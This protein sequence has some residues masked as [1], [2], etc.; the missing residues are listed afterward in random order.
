[1]S[2]L[3]SSEGGSRCGARRE[4]T[5]RRP[6]PRT[7]APGAHHVAPSGRRVARPPLTRRGFLAVCGLGGRGRRCR[8]RGAA[9]WRRASR[10]RAARSFSTRA[11][12]RSAS[13]VTHPSWWGTSSCTR[14]WSG[15]AASARTGPAPTTTSSPHVAD[16]VAAAGVARGEP[17]DRPRRDGALGLSSYPAFSSPQE[18]GAAEAAAGFDVALRASN[19]ALRRGPWRA[20]TPMLSVLA[21]RAP[22]RGGRGRRRQ[23]GRRRGGAARGARR[24]PDRHPELRLHDERHPAAQRV[25]G[26]DALGRA[27]RRRRGG[28]ARGRRR[29]DRG[30]PALGDGVHGGPRRR[31][32]L[33]GSGARGRRRGPH[34]GRPSPRPAAVRGRSSSPRTAAR[35][36][37]SGP[38]ATSSPAS[39]AWTRWW[40]AWRAPPSPS[41]GDRAA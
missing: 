40:A 35:C 10:G 16:H 3:S 28:G 15:G 33:L 6:T 30:V 19:H 39:S 26:P 25:V 23:R 32:A 37:C 34:R 7:K 11:P 20:S 9:A 5:P 31:P 18:V 22:R 4:P 12:P 13:D 21:R 2:P 1:M 17:G 38:W 29:G 27:G 41:R 8:L 14:A 24:A 36:P